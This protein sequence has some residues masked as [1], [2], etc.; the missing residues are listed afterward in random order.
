MKKLVSNGS[1]AILKGILGSPLVKR[2]SGGTL[3]ATAFKIS[4]GVKHPLVL[5][6]VFMLGASSIK[7]PSDEESNSNGLRS[8]RS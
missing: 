1:A 6:V 7:D 5:G 4:T 8:G 3:A 2:V